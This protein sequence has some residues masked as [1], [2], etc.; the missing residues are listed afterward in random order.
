[1]RDEA[2]PAEFLEEEVYVHRVLTW[3]W[4]RQGASFIEGVVVCS[5]YVPVFPQWSPAPDSRRL[6]QR[7][8][9]VTKAL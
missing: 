8:L 2:S 9:H 5:M 7:P 4:N 1:M 3:Y 6:G